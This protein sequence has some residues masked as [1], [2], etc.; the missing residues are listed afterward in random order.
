[1]SEMEQASRWYIEQQLGEGVTSKSRVW[2]QILR[3]LDDEE[4]PLKKLDDVDKTH[5]LVLLA[6][7]SHEDGVHELGRLR[8]LGES[9]GIA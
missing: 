7:M 1:M 4:L 8:E 2:M 9:R 5:L 6:S 3:V